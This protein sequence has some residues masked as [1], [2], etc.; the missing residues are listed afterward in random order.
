ME[1]LITFLTNVVFLCRLRK[2]F[3]QLLEETG[4]VTPGKKL[5]EVNVVL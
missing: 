1:F 3:K 2:D 4:Y 5:D